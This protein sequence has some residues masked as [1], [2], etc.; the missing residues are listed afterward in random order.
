MKTFLK[1]SISLIAGLLDGFCVYL[2]A[3]LELG[4]KAALLLA[5]YYGI[6]VVALS[7]VLI[8]FYEEYNESI[9]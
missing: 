5:I 4:W 6:L 2:I 8:D 3:Y 1:I 7:I 9:T